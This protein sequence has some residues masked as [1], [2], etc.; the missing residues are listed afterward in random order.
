MAQ[1][2]EHLSGE[3]CVECKNRNETPLQPEMSID[4]GGGKRIGLCTKHLLP[5]VESCVAYNLKDGT[6]PG[7][8]C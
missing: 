5:L 3:E 1:L 6:S 7:T 8:V 4:L 2:V